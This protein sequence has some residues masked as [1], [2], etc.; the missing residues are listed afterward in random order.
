MHWLT[1]TAHPEQVARRLL[2][3]QP[4]LEQLAEQLEPS[5][6][7]AQAE[8]WAGT[9]RYLRNR[10]QATPEERPGRK[11]DMSAAAA[12]AFRAVLEEVGGVAVSPLE[13]LLLA[14]VQ[15]RASLTKGVEI[16]WR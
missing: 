1:L 6:P 13:E 11:P 15:G 9:A 12:A 2:G 14:G 16:A 7:P 8:A 4:G 3:Q 5:T 10:T